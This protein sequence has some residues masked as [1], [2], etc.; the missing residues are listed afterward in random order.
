VGFASEVA[1]K[2]RGWFARDKEQANLQLARGQSN[3]RF[4][5]QAGDL[6]N[7]LGYDALA[8]YL[9]LEA[10]LLSRYSDYED[11]DD[12]PEIATAIDIFADDATQPNTPINRT[13]WVTSR[14]LTVQ[15]TLDDLLHKRLRLDEEIWEI[16]RTM[17]KYGNDFE[18]LLITKDGVVG[19]NFLPAPTIRRVEAEKGQLLGF[20]QDY[21]GKFS[22]TPTEFMQALNQRSSNIANNINVGQNSAAGA[23]GPKVVPMEGWEVV[24]FRLRSKHRRSVYGF[25]VLE[26]ARWIWKRLMLL[27]D[28]ALIYRL[29]RAPERFAFY[30]DVGD[31]PP[32]EALAYLNRVRQQY[33]KKKWVNPTTG[34][35]DLKFNPLG[36]DEDFFVPSR[37]GTDGTRIDVLGAPQWQSM[38]DI[39]YFRS[40]LF[41]AMKVPKSYLGQD[42]GTA[43]AVLSAED[44]RFARTVLRVQRELRNGLRKVCRVHLSA[45]GVDPASVEYDINMTVPSAVFEL[46]QM[47]VRNA[48]ADLANRM[49]EF[50]SLHWILSKVFDMSDAD[51]ETIMKQRGGDV[52]RDQIALASA[53]AASNAVMSG[54]PG[55]ENPEDQPQESSPATVAKA[56]REGQILLSPTTRSL[57]HRPISEKELFTGSRESERRAEDKLNQLL[58]SDKQL[59][60]RIE[61]M[62]GMLSD[63]KAVSGGRR[64]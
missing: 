43:R 59:A 36:Q 23:Y 5:G 42:A 50:V 29:Q 51:I 46:A 56:L 30:V 37:K 12:Y 13:V 40:K 3:D 39:E 14:D 53:Q 32:T 57:R 8:E 60:N 15:H 25:S 20:M 7:N 38:E 11:M 17:V 1:N 2:V 31:L 9:K 34:R 21:K 62:R 44:V 54:M 35:V 33:K 41:A 47:E 48:R 52:S 55:S 26:S 45:L 64:R 22:Y 28:A 19:L 16:A 24:H 61:E 10:D 4:P 58:K 49:R 6:L 63:L 18:E 27:E